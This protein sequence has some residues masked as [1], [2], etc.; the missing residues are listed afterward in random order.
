MVKCEHSFYPFFVNYLQDIKA[1]YYYIQEKLEKLYYGT[2]E[3][4]PFDKGL[5]ILVKIFLYLCYEDC[6]FNAIRE[7]N[8]TKETD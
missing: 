8:I 6:Y 7:G 2:T 3:R 4:N 5:Y 1:R